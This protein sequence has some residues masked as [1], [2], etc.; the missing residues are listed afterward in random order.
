MNCLELLPVRGEEHFKLQPTKQDL[1]TSYKILFKIADEHKRAFCMAVAPPPPPPHTLH[2]RG[3]TSISQGNQNALLKHK[4]SFIHRCK[5]QLGNYKFS[6][7]FEDSQI[8]KH[9]IHCLDY[10]LVIF[11]SLRETFSKMQIF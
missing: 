10:V 9:T 8:L 1:G 4:G 6:S 11:P 5:R 2:P 7:Y 3:V